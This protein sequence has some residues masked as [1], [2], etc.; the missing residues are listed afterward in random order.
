MI[1]K[2]EAIVLKAFDYR[3]T[4]RI[5]RFFTKDYGKVSG[6]LKGIRKDPKKFGSHVDKF[7]VND[8]VYYQYRNSDLHLI[9]QCDL[10]QFFF[11]IRQDYKRSLA[12]NYSLELVDVI[13][14]TEQKN[15]EIYQLMLDYFKNLETVKD[16][17]KLVH[18]F[19]IKV[20]LGSGFRPH[21]DSCVRCERKVHD[22]VRF[23]LSLGGLVCPNCPT[24]EAHVT[25]ISQGTISSMLHIEQGDWPQCLRLGL[26]DLVRK[27]L[28][29]LLNNFLV[30]H[31]GKRIKTAKY[32]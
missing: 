22:H 7:S 11:P 12:A 3:E 18:I 31:L 21:I 25:A 9:S 29:Y 32:L 26:T 24:T 20:L 19:Q 5:A 27:E 8:I 13:M 28:K 30:Y 2:T 10:K 15:V 16:V 4:S 14:P 17:D 6:V 1:I 23:S